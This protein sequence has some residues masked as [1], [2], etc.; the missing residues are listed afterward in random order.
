MEAPSPFGTEQFAY[1]DGEVWCEDVPVAAL[2]ARFGTPLYVYSQ[3]AIEARFAV[4]R[5]AFGPSAHICF[6]V[7]SNGNLSLL[8]LLARLGAGFDLVSG[9]E[10]ERLRRAGVPTSGAVFAGVGKDEAEV[11]AAHAAG[12]LFFNV[13]SDFEL[14]LFERVGSAQRPVPIALRLNPDVDAGTHHYIATGRG[15]DKFGM[16]LA[17]AAAVVER[18]GASPRLALVG[19][20]VHLGSQVRQRDPYLA[21]LDVVERFLDA[22]PSHARGARYY[23]LGGGFAVAYGQ[24][25]GGTDVGALAAAVLPRLAARGLTPVVEPGRFL[26]ADAGILVARVLGAKGRF[27]IVD[28]AMN[29]L[30]RPALYR[31]EHPVAPVRLGDGEVAVR[32]IVGPVCESGDFLA[33]GRRLPPLAPGDLLSV[34]SAGAYG[35]AM[36]SNYNSRRRPA[37]VLVAGGDARLIRRRERYEDLWAAEI[38]L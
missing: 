10:L 32:D 27:T 33:L 36:A 7:K 30:L 28:A 23:D 13:E 8:R 9:G 2:A 34:C 17:T 25:G 15:A 12:I 11:R 35:S 6:A 5:R 38:E 19:Y 18:I 20:H 21:A 31:A 24:A 14:E 37:E 1:R 26:I 16:D 3:A 4:V 29:D 22:K